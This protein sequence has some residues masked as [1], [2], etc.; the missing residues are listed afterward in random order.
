MLFGIN[1]EKINVKRTHGIVD[2]LPKIFLV[3]LDLAFFGILVGA[4][5]LIPLD[6]IP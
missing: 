1:L 2:A 6:H 4:Y 5:G 3:P